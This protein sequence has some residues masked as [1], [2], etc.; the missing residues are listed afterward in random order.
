MDVFFSHSVCGWLEFSNR[1]PIQPQRDHHNWNV[2]FKLLEWQDIQLLRT[3]RQHMEREWVDHWA[4]NSSV[5]KTKNIGRKKTASQ[6]MVRL[7]M[8][9]QTNERSDSRGGRGHGMDLCCGLTG[10]VTSWRPRTAPL[11]HPVIQSHGRNHGA[12]VSIFVE[13][14]GKCQRMIQIQG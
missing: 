7:E 10:S 5:K 3:V 12:W 11:Q 6:L 9:L 2:E 8:T 14:N 4:E 13:R 1:K